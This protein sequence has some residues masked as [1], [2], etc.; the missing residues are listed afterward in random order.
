M[1]LPTGEPGW[2]WRRMIIFPVVAFAAW[3]LLELEDNPDSRLNEALAGNWFMIIL[4]LVLCYT[5]FATIQDAIAIWRTKSG[6][7]Y[8]PA[9]TPAAEGNTVVVNTA[10]GGVQVAV[11]PDQQAG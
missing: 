2:K 5:G 6:L 3:R 8:S 11:P 10:P 7:P 1:A 4:V 9:T